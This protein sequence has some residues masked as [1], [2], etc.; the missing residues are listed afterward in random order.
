MPFKSE[1]QRRYLWAKHPQIAE[2]WAKEY[3]NQ[4]SLPRHVRKPKQQQR[5]RQQRHLRS[6]PDSKGY[7]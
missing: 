3:P 1:A 5:K 2:R 7:Y 6:K 4:K